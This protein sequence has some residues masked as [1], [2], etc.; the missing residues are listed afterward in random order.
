MA[1][2]HY[3]KVANNNIFENC[4]NRKCNCNA[5]KMDHDFPVLNRSPTAEKESG[6]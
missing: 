6:K 1:H 2:I 3:I 5:E 4:E